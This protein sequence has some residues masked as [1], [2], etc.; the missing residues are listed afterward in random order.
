MA[1]LVSRKDLFNF[2]DDFFS[3][4]FP[5]ISDDT[6]FDVDIIDNEKNYEVKADLPG[7]NKD[8]IHVEYDKD[9]LSI[10]AVREDRVD[11]KDEEG[12]YIRRERSS[13]SFSRQ[14]YI[15]DIDEE[16]ITATFKDGVLDLILPKT[17]ENQKDRKRIEIQ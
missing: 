17:D 8:Q 10:R 11:E 12:N 13:R 16:Q 6:R 14:F 5:S 4:L 1:N 2:N 9:I 15:K 3:N 7:F